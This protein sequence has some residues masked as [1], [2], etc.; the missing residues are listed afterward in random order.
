MYAENVRG[1]VYAVVESNLRP[2]SVWE[3]VE[4]PRLIGNPNVTKIVGI[5]PE[6]RL[7]KIIFER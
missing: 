3:T 6:I 5:D 1:E 2:R 7:Q 4:L